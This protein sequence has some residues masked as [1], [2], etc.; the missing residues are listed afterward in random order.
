[1]PAGGRDPGHRGSN[2]SPERWSVR[3]PLVRAARELARVRDE[4]VRVTATGE[5]LFDLHL[6]RLAIVDPEPVPVEE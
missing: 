2:G 1:V 5:E 3:R 6:R 4:R